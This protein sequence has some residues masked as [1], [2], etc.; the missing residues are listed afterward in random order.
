M[1]SKKLRLEKKLVKKLETLLKKYDKINDIII[2]GSA[3]K[4]KEMPKDIDIALIMGQRD[5][6]VYN[7]VNK[8]LGNKKVHIE[9]VKSSSLLKNRLSL[10]LLME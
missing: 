10:N 2:F 5:M 6:D 7:N 4:G 8:Y 1:P 9:M 3:A